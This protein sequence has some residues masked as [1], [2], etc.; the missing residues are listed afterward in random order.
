VS[1]LVYK[2]F[3]KQP[4]QLVKQHLFLAAQPRG[5]LETERG[6]AR[7]ARVVFISCHG[8]FL[9]NETYPH[10]HS[11]AKRGRWANWESRL[12]GGVLAQPRIHIPNRA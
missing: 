7:M 10:L 11:R 9:F 4:E 6:C 2:F 12:P 8:C 1:R 3:W 5:D